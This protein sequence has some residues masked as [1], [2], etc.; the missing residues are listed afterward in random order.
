MADIK[1]LDTTQLERVIG[2]L[3]LPVAFS[4]Y[5]IGSSVITY[6]FDLKNPRDWHKVKKTVEC[7]SIQLHKDIKLLKS[8]T[9]SFSLAIPREK[10]DFPLFSNYHKALQGKEPGEILFGIDT[11]GKPFTMNLR[12]TKSLLVAGSSGGG[13][14]VCM[15]N[16]LCSLI[17]YT[18]PE[19]CGLVLIDLKRVEF[20]LF[21]NAEHLVMPVQYDYN[22]AIKA[23]S[24]VKKEIDKRYK[25]MQ[26][27]GIRKATIDKYPLLVVAIDEYAM[28]SSGGDKAELDKIVGYIA[29]TGRACNVFIVV[30]T[31]H[32]ISTIISNTIKSN[33]QSRIGLRTTNIAQSSCILG[34]RDCVD[35]LGYGDSFMS[36]DGVAGLHRV[37]TC[38]ITDDD[39]YKMLENQNKTAQNKPK[40]DKTKKKPLAKRISEFLA[41]LGVKTQW[42]KNAEPYSVDCLNY[43]N[44]VIDND[45][46]E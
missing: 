35:L 36:I 8:K 23:L 37:Q 10:R 18:K 46:E 12:D 17:C 6:D 40:Q 16:I 11:L 25:S 19:Q 44:C 20:K 7:L 29:A 2:N 9:S 26:L 1:I 30:A 34:T 32:A 45:D 14:S 22:G 28:L 15:S 24:S 43:I 31:Q 42:R 13:K 5:S 4:C 3:G 27:H 38:N 21:E 33:L 39:I 41:K